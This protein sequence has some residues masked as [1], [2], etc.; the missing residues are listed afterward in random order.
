MYFVSHLST[1]LI[2]IFISS[3]ING[4][5]LTNEIILEEFWEPDATSLDLYSIDIES[6]Q[7]GAFKGLKTLQR[8]DLSH[9]ILIE[10]HSDT[11]KGLSNLT[12]LNIGN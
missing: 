1:L 10:L 12:N 8:L 6:I 11:F 7:P 4:F 9:N 5:I 3:K 2:L